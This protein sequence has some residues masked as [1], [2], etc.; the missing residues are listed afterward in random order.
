MELLT[1][2]QTSNCRTAVGETDAKAK[3]C[4]AGGTVQIYLNVGDQ[5]R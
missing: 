3:A 2:P 1:L 4:W 5:S